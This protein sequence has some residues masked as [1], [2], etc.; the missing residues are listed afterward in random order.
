MNT[1]NKPSRIA[2]ITKTINGFYVIAYTLMQEGHYQ[3][4]SHAPYS[5]QPVFPS[6]DEALAFIKGFSVDSN[7]ITL[8]G[9]HLFFPTNLIK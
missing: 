4:I 9:E 7:N 8:N 6:L 1:T 5:K 2:N 3:C